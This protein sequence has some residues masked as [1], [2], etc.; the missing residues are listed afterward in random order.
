MAFVNRENT[1]QQGTLFVQN[2]EDGVFKKD[3]LINHGIEFMGNCEELTLDSF[4]QFIGSASYAM[5]R[6]RIGKYSEVK[7]YGT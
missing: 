1:Q 4:T 3:Y 7:Y 6:R 5:M 2:L